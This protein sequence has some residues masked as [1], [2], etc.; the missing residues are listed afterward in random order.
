MLQ[1]FMYAPDGTLRRGR[2]VIVLP[3]CFVAAM[4]GPALLWLVP[5]VTDSEP[6]RW[7]G[8]LIA[9]FMLKIPLI[10]LIFMFIRRNLEVPTRPPRWEAPEVA[11]ILA[12]IARQA[13]EAGARKDGPARLAFLSREAWHVADR[14]DGDDRIAALTVALQIDERLIVLREKEQTG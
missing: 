9:T 14:V 1:R 6:G 4:F 5:Q 13:E 12:D 8:V 2:L 3:V 11:E 10:L 7:L